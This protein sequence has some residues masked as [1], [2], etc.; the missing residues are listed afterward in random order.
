MDNE[1]KKLLMDILITIEAIEGYI[2]PK[3]TFTEVH[4]LLNG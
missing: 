2:G 3:K 4:E 1:I